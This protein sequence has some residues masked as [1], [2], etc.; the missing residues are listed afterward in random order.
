MSSNSTCCK[1]SRHSRSASDCICRTSSL[2]S[3]DP[4][5]GNESASLGSSS[6]DARSYVDMNEGVEGVFVAMSR[7]FSLYEEELVLPRLVIASRGSIGVSCSLD[8]NV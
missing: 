3:E 1:L 2:E 5:S 4:L 6:G 8:A 7:V